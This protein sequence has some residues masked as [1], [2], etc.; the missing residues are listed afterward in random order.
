MDPDF[1]TL[2]EEPIAPRRE[3][4][5]DLVARLSQLSVSKH[6]DAY[7]DVPWDDPSSRIEVEDPVWQLGGDHPLGASAWYAEQRPEVRARIGLHFV[8]CAM[9][10]GAEFEN[11]LTRGLLNFAVSLPRGAP[12]YR[13]AYH[14]AIEESQ[15]TLM[16]QE[17]ITRSGLDPGRAPFM[18]R[19]GWGPVIGFARHFPELFFLFVLGG[20]DPIDYVQRM[21]LR[22]ERAVHPLLRRIMQIHITE[23]ARHL[24]FARAYLKV[25]VPALRPVRRRILAIA[26]P[27]ALGSV[28]RRMLDPPPA[29][30][31]TYKIPRAVVARDYRRSPIQRERIRNA[32]SKARTLCEELDLLTPAARR[33]WRAMGIA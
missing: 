22:S 26:A 12:E 17:F 23:E 24:C 29:V 21:L 11:V 30:V 2:P 33:I 19:A 10:T 18:M 28:A 25:R 13:Y 14:E 5:P 20:E 32:L 7:A 27:L 8:T 6:Y 31:R 4:F 1:T 9:Q 16:F 3:S 15:H